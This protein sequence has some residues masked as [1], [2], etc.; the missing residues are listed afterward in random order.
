MLAASLL[1]GSAALADDHEAMESGDLWLPS[2]VTET[3]QE[4]SHDQ[5]TALSLPSR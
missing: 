3:P 2:L 1:L 5:G 4:G